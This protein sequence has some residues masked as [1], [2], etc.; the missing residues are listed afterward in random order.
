MARPPDK[1]KDIAIVAVAHTK[2]ARRT[3]RSVF[4]IAG[5]VLAQMLDRTGI[6]KAD[7]DGLGVCPAIAEAGN[8][9]WSNFMADY[10]GLSVRWLQST[11]LG[12]ATH[13]ANV[14]R[15]ASALREGYCRVVLLL[16]ADAPT[17]RSRTD[18]GGYRAEWEEVVG[19]L[20][21]PGEFGLLSRRYEQRYGLMPEALGKIAI[22]Q[23]EGAVLNPNACDTFRNRLTMAEYLSSR[24]I[25]DPVR[26][27]DCVM[28]CDGG[29]AVLM[30]TTRRARRMGF[31]TLVHP[32]GYAEITNLDAANPLPE[33]TDTGFAVVGPAALKRAGLRPA[34][35]AMFH[36]Y[37]DFTIAILMQLEQ[38]GFCRRGRGQAFV[39]DNDLS[40]RG[41]LPVN[42][43]GGQLSTGQ[44]GLAAGMVN[45]AEAVTQM[46]GEAGARQVADPRN[47]LVTGI[48]MVPLLRNW[49]T[50][51]ALVLER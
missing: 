49:G 38:I 10:L 9:F 36:G 40:F 37:D 22:D 13:I 11:D 33:V 45:L 31:K 19:L 29:A 42:S 23:R 16:G 25:S 26:L 8:P 4:D 28:P 48:G 18:F 5:E 7:I 21:P 43:G 50:S 46:F 34:D 12:G 6:D 32:T 17:T 39:L 3:G 24:M 30:T 14:A 27:L 35:I 20:G 44:P 41:R 2:L 51:A 47:A 15:A 1:A